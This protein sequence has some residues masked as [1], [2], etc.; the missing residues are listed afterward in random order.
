MKA[1]KV[2]GYLHNCKFVPHTTAIAVSHKQTVLTV[3]NQHDPSNALCN[4]LKHDKYD[5]I[6]GSA[7]QVIQTFDI[8]PDGTKILSITLEQASC[9][10]FHVLD[11]VDD[12]KFV[13]REESYKMDPPVTVRNCAISPNGKTALI[14]AVG[15]FCALNLE[16][17]TFIGEVF[18]VQKYD[19]THDWTPT[20]CSFVAF[21]PC[22]KY[23]VGGD[24]LGRM[25]VFGDQ[26]NPLA[27]PF[28]IRKPNM[29]AAHIGEATACAFGPN[30]SIAT[31]G[32]D[33]VIR[34]WQLNLPMIRRLQ[35]S[36]KESIIDNSD[37]IGL[38]CCIK[39]TLMGHRSVIYDIAWSIDG[40]YIASVSKDSFL[41]LWNAETTSAI[42]MLPLGIGRKCD[43]S[44]DG[45]QLL[46][47]TLDGSI[48][49]VDTHALVNGDIE[50]G[51]KVPKHSSNWSQESATLIA[52]AGG[53]GCLDATLNENGVS[54]INDNKPD[55]TGGKD[56][57]GGFGYAFQA[58]SGGAGWKSGAESLQVN[59][60]QKSATL[61]PAL[62]DPDG[63][64]LGAFF[65]DGHEA[66]CGGLG[67]G[68]N[69]WYGSGGGGGYSGG[70]GSSTNG[71]G[72]GGGSYFAKGIEGMKI[73]QEGTVKNKKTGNATITSP[74]GKVLYIG[75]DMNGQSEKLGFDLVI[76]PLPNVQ[77]DF[78][79]EP[80]GVVVYEVKEAGEY[81]IAL[82]GA[83]CK[84]ENNG[85][86]AD[87][88]FSL[89]LQVGN[90]IGI[91]TGN[92]GF[93]G[94]QGSGAS[95]AWLITDMQDAFAN[96][97]TVDRASSALE[98][99]TRGAKVDDKIC[100]I[101]LAIPSEGLPDSKWAL[102]VTA[103]T[104][105]SKTLVSKL[106][107]LRSDRL[108]SSMTSRETLITS[109][110]VGREEATL[111]LLEQGA[112]FDEGAF[113]A[114]T[115]I[116]VGLE[117]R[118]RLWHCIRGGK[119]KAM[120][121]KLSSLRAEV[122]DYAVREALHCSSEDSFAI[123]QWLFD[124]NLRMS[125]ALSSNLLTE[126]NQGQL[127]PFLGQVIQNVAKTSKFPQKLIICIVRVAPDTLGPIAVCTFMNLHWYDEALQIL[128][129]V[130]I[131]TIALREH[132]ILP[133]GDASTYFH[134]AVQFQE[135]QELI[136]YLVLH[137]LS[138]IHDCKDGDDRAAY[139]LAV[140]ANR[141]RMDDA[142]SFCGRYRIVS[143]TPEHKS[144]TSVV[145]RAKDVL[146]DYREVIVKLM[147]NEDQFKREV[148]QRE[149]TK[150]ASQENGNNG[151]EFDRYTVGIIMSSISDAIRDRWQ[152]DVA[153]N[154]MLLDG[155]S[156]AQYP[157]GIVM[158]A[159][160]RNLQ[161]IYLQERPSLNAIRS[162]IEQILLALKMF[163]DA[164]V[165]HGDIKPLNVVRLVSDHQLRLIDF[166]AAANISSTSTM[167]FA[168]SKFS[169]G[170]IPPE[171]WVKLDAGQKK[172]YDDYW[173]KYCTDKDLKQKV[174]PLA[175]KGF[176]YVVRTYLVENDKLVKIE[177]L[178]Y[179][180]I[181]ASA[182]IDVWALGVMM[183]QLCVGKPLLSTSR[184]D[185]LLSG[186][187]ASVVCTWKDTNAYDYLKNVTDEVARDMLSKMLSTQNRASVEELLAHPFIKVGMS[188]NGKV[189]REMQETLNKLINQQQQVL[190]K[191]NR[192]E[193]RTASIE[194]LT[195]ATKGELSRG[196]SELKKRIA[197]ASDI[198]IP[199]CFVICPLVSDELSLKE[200]ALMLVKN[201]QKRDLGSAAEH[202]M[203]VLSKMKS[204]YDTVST[205]VA[206]PLNSIKQKFKELL[207]DSEFQ[208][209]LIC[210][211]CYEPQTTSQWPI[212]LERASDRKIELA[213]KV[214]PIAKAGL[215]V[216]AVFNT[217]AGIGRLLGYPIPTIPIEL[218]EKNLDF[219]ESTSSV[220]DYSALEKK[221]FEAGD[222]SDN[223]QK[224]NQEG[225]MMREYRRFLEEFDPKQDWGQLQ[226]LLLD[227]GTAMWCCEKC[228]GVVKTHNDATFDQLRAIVSPK[229]VVALTTTT[230][231]MTIK[232]N[233]ILHNKED[234]A[235]T[236]VRVASSIQQS[237]VQADQVAAR[238]DNA[239]VAIQSQAIMAMQTRLDR[240]ENTVDNT[241]AN[242][243]A[244]TEEV[245]QIQ[246]RLKSLEANNGTSS[247][248]LCV[249]RFVKTHPMVTNQETDGKLPK[250]K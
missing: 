161:L 37:S 7:T 69:G 112:K 212:K 168:A 204:L 67:G 21:S 150:M 198:T 250:G 145:I 82:H 58:G 235:K 135:A 61:A 169:S 50:G 1:I 81:Q 210:Q 179:S 108:T 157:H 229:E 116:P 105:D 121:Q 31:C 240:L 38:G 14:G 11:K 166:D 231:Q 219:L 164:E 39:Y 154:K 190:E 192:I 191:L 202:S 80:N 170:Y 159:G 141:L 213:A 4:P 142:E 185:D 92:R 65:K 86:G 227:E 196:V 122:A 34:V 222:K 225:Y 110:A 91:L 111:R 117:M 146:Q 153:N 200:E 85:R 214:L 236:L 126:R 125:P 134:Q 139:D 232:A 74:N 207:G 59:G 230:K 248:F 16:S 249:P 8:T 206:N 221:L 94:D 163:H 42:S 46:A 89:Q 247:T 181:H 78:I 151:D 133:M 27:S 5:N 20:R 188:G 52:I 178:P 215:Q 180:P 187:D 101:L 84:D 201:V 182:D 177:E 93:R 129:E 106:A 73:T 234:M 48:K 54:A 62:S 76:P 131:S 53:A 63:L 13:P 209:F 144:A 186:K 103:S 107:Q 140:K 246:H 18:H 195:L 25:W 242:Q 165:I 33:N 70:G 218:V 136:H 127:L 60:T 238:L 138:L 32:Y 79:F 19:R 72:G 156:C 203:K 49:I 152:K 137:D 119:C 233:P 2:Q 175:F 130:A 199:T 83:G 220:A 98:L 44:A 35:D 176:Y 208:M 45:N 193:E 43:F 87:L 194:Q 9:S 30:D 167:P 102:L 132:L 243:K 174:K 6:E 17:M 217:A 66:S 95:I 223:Q 10:M 149:A 28:S 205:T 115:Q 22:G 216:A 245:Q 47:A 237:D 97:L 64:F 68:G 104:A 75:S 113:H 173:N 24:S 128:Q 12:G 189:D 99:L 155:I 77:S 120:V 51:I 148:Y 55:N 184:D 241:K 171:L 143:K 197:S 160:D 123:C 124:L 100:N 29:T 172:Q 147:A 211:L 244:T 114:L 183:Y 26:Q 57:K 224:E 96:A 88:F 109:F 41:R 228:V 15:R 226:R 158:V 71:R 118:S 56:G 90:M 162:Y 40:K 36:H 239:T 3:L 23:C